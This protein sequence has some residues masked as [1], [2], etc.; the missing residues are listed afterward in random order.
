MTTFFFRGAGGQ[1]APLLFP[2]CHRVVDAADAQ[3]DEDVSGA[4]LVGADTV[5]NLVGAAFTGLVGEVWVG[6]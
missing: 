3:A 6:D 1:D 2:T 5:A 4:A